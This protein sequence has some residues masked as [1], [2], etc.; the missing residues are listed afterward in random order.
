M[1]EL[2]VVADESD[3]VFIMAV[4]PALGVFKGLTAVDE[5]PREESGDY[6]NALAMVLLHNS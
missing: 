3:R 6:T 1:V 2:S 4:P 5:V